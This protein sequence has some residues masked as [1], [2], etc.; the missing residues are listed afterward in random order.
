MKK[1]TQHRNIFEI[2]EELN[3]HPDLVHFEYYTKEG[4]KNI[5]I[6]HMHNYE[7]EIQ[8]SEEEIE[9]FTKTS[10]EEYKDIV[11]EAYDYALEYNSMDECTD[12]LIQKWLI[13]N[14]KK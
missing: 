12:M 14:L 3:A 4:L 13:K 2:I 5:F 7:D 8:L 6:D 11:K 10:F 9:N 1:R